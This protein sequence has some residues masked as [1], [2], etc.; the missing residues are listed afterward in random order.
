[1]EGRDCALPYSTVVYYS[2]CTRCLCIGSAALDLRKIWFCSIDGQNGKTSTLWLPVLK[3]RETVGSK[4]RTFPSWGDNTCLNNPRVSTCFDYY[5]LCTSWTGHIMNVFGLIHTW[6]V[7]YKHWL[8]EKC[9][10]YRTKKN[11]YTF[12]IPTTV[13][14]L[15]KNIFCLIFILVF[16]MFYFWSIILCF[17]S[18][19]K[20]Y[21]RSLMWVFIVTLM[22]LECVYV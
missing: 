11:W 4:S 1:M 16:P 15:H 17:A 12:N 19:Q 10:S 21:P 20:S 8:I 5:N 18:T 9:H 22:T 13:L 7:T 14:L 6:Q 2:S 3:G